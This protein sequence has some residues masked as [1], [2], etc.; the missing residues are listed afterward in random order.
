[1]ASIMLIGKNTEFSGDLKKRHE[2]TTVSN[3]KEASAALLDGRFD[4]VILDSIS[5]RTPGERTARSLK[6]QLNGVPLIHLYPGTK[7]AETPADVVLLPPFSARKIQNAIGRLLTKAGHEGDVLECGPWGLNV[8][9]RLLIADGQE[10]SLTPK[11]AQLLEVFFRHPGET[12]DRKILMEKVWQTDYLGDT[13]TLDVHIRW[14]RRAIEQDPSRPRHLI[15][16]RGVG[17]RFEAPAL[18]PTGL[19]IPQLS[20]P[21]P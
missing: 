2:V 9:R 18:M 13:R 12:L 19:A 11:L 21:Q 7:A 8:D 17:Y 10:I 1:M 6:Q 20:L 14:I 4:V 5:L 16:L 3:G 15:T